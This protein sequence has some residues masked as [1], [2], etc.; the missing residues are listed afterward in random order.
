MNKL[1]NRALAVVIAL[2]TTVAAL[3]FFSSNQ[4]ESQFDTGT[5]EWVVQQYLMAMFDGDTDKA[6]G[7]IA[8]SSPCNVTHL[9]RAWVDRNASIDLV[10]V[11]ITG[12]TA[13]VEVDVEF[14]DGDLFSTPFVESHIYRLERVVDDWLITGVPWPVYDCGEIPK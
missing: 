3:V 11:T 7:Y 14:G 9:D 2:V 5:P 13:R 1:P 6:I 4:T 8:D 12:Q 10:E